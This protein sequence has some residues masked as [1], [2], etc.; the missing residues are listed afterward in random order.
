MIRERRIEFEWDEAN[1]RHLRRHKVSPDE[2]E[3][4]V[5]N[6]PVFTDIEEEK[7]EERYHAVGGTNG[8]R[9]LI[10]IFSYRDGRIRPITAWDAGKSAREFYFLTVGRQDG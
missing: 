6:D 7:G 4:A 2:F 8:L 1:I 10:L 5:R 3:E 9:I